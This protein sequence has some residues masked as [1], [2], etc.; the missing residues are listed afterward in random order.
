MMEQAQNPISC[1][2]W[3]FRVTEGQ[4]RTVEQAV[5]S[6]LTGALAPYTFEVLC[7]SGAVSAEMDLT[8]RVRV[9][10][11]WCV[12]ETAEVEA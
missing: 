9:K 12:T 6:A 8:Y 3:R 4:G 10:T 7:L 1:I 2:S 11:S 5:E